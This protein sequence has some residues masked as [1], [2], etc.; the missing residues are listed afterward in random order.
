[1]A[2]E[3]LKVAGKLSRVDRGLRKWMK[4]RVEPLDSMTALSSTLIRMKRSLTLVGFTPHQSA[5][6]MLSPTI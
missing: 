2:D 6:V 4:I 5:G 3:D 1:M